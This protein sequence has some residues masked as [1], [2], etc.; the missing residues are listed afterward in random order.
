MYSQNWVEFEVVS[1][2][3]ERLETVLLVAIISQENTAA[4][5]GL[6]TGN[7][8]D[9]NNSNAGGGT[10]NQNNNVNLTQQVWQTIKGNRG[11]GR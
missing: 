8:S 11:R 3:P 10:I 1:E 7:N 6:L 9:V 5:G 2:L 4:N